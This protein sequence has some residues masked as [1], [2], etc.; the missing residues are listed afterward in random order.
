M[1]VYDPE[2]N[3]HEKDPVDAR[4]CI[5]HCG[6]TTEPKTAEDVDTGEDDLPAADSVKAKKGK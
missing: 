5:K 2:G 1:Q 3:A 4:E 6:Y